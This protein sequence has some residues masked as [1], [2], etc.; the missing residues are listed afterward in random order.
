MMLGL[1]LDMFM[2]WFKIVVVVSDFLD[3]YCCASVVTLIAL[4]FGSGLAKC[5]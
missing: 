1:G 2:S 3:P 4:F 5:S